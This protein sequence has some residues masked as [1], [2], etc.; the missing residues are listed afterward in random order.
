M[1]SSPA[2]Y[3]D[4]NILRSATTKQFEFCVSILS[5]CRDL[6]KSNYF[7]HKRYSY[8]SQ[9]FAGSI[10]KQRLFDGEKEGN[11]LL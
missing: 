5:K 7:F 6:A 1:L 8:R 10:L 9:V 11:C 2:N 3:L 4:A